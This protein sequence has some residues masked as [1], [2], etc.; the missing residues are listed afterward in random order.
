MNAVVLDAYYIAAY[1][2][3]RHVPLDKIAWRHHGLGMLQ[4]ELSDHLR[5]HIWHPKLRHIAG[6]MRAVH[7]HRF[8]L[9]SAVIVG[10]VIDT[11]YDVDVEANGMECSRCYN[12]PVFEIAHAKIQGDGPISRRVGFARVQKRVSARYPNGIVYHVPRRAFHTTEIDGLAVTVVARSD[13]DDKPARVLDSGESGI[14]KPDLSHWRIG[15]E[16]VELKA[17]RSHIIQLAS[18]ALADLE[19]L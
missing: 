10:S 11:R 4:G 18:N 13:F 19:P 7:D 5:V 14:V 17:L 1:E 8:E 15:D 12:V 9:V 2:A 16:D 6:E 3:Q